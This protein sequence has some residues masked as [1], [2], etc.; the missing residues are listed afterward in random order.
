MKY[1]RP[2]IIFYTCLSAVIYCSS[3]LVLAEDSQSNHP[4]TITVTS[5]NITSTI[6]LG[7]TVEPKRVVNLSA[8]MPGDVSF[9]GGSEGDAFSRGQPLVALDTSILRAKRVKVTSQLAIAHATHRNAIIQYNHELQNPNSQANAMLGGAPSLFGMFADPMRSFTGQGDPDT[10]RHANLFA[11]QVHVETA[12]NGIHQAQAS[13]R[14]I[15]EAIENAISHAPFNGVILKKMVEEGDIVQPGMP[16]I[17]FADISYL[18]IRAEVPTRLLNTLRRSPPKHAILDGHSS[19]VNITVDRIFPMATLGGNTT[20]VQFKLPPNFL[21]HPGMYAEIVLIDLNTDI[22]ALP[23]IPFSAITWRG[24]LP[25]VF[26]VDAQGNRK[27]RLIRI[28][29][30]PSGGNISVIS[31]IAVGD[32]ILAHP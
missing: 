6:T 12:F 31:G 10:E 4:E 7:G 13:L 23:V 11:K 9:I 28:D 21:A 26:L 32:R 17:S 3:S 24:S 20:T 15:D 29:E 2:K 18:Q 27:L 25:A 5:N 16:L 1:S 22:T 14:E 19:P 8:Q 30:Q